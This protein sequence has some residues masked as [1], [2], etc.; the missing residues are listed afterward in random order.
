MKLSKIYSPEAGQEGGAPPAVH[1]PTP[2]NWDSVAT[3]DQIDEPAAEPAAIDPANGDVNKEA[4]A[5]AEAEK[6]TPADVTLIEKEEKAPEKKEDPLLDPAAVEEPTLDLTDLDLT[7]DKPAASTEKNTSWNDVGQAIGLTVESDSPEAFAKAHTE[8]LES[9]RQEGRKAGI[10]EKYGDGA[11]HF[12]ELYS[13][14]V[15]PYELQKELQPMDEFLSLTNAED[16]VYEVLVLKGWKDEVAIQEK[17]QELKTENK[18]NALAEQATVNMQA[19]RDRI[20]N[21]FITKHSE[22]QAKAKESIQNQ[23]KAENKAVADVIRKT[24]TYLGYK[25]PQDAINA[26]ADKVEKGDF[27]ALWKDPAKVAKMLLDFNLSEKVVKTAKAEVSKKEKSEVMDKLHNLDTSKK[28]MSPAGKSSV[29]KEGD[30][31]DPFAAFVAVGKEGVKSV[32]TY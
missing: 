4:Q 6:K 12:L 20:E 23:I 17:I 28:S 8:A 32:M 10:N 14:G 18:L 27:R 19:E 24:S 3:I 25:L 16:K 21:D 22:V 13:K 9:A 1:T 26:L 7:G 29:S 31:D 11:E 15:N 5:A 30:T 2:T